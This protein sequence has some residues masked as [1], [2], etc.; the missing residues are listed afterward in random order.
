[1][2]KV[3]HGAES[4]ILWLQRDF[5]IYVAGL[6][7]TGQASRVLQLKSNA[8][9]HLLRHYC[10]VVVRPPFPRAHNHVTSLRRF[11]SSQASKL[12]RLGGRRNCVMLYRSG[13]KG[14]AVRVW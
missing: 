1:M 12:G 13:K 2:V 4:D 14:A 6:F 10:G 11:R 9:A 7:D 5:G 8:L 3:L